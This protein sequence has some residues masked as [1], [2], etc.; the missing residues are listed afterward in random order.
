[1]DLAATESPKTVR[2]ALGEAFVQGL[3]TREALSGLLERHPRA[4]GLG[5]LRALLDEDPALTRSDAEDQFRT[6]MERA[7]LPRPAV[8][9]SVEGR[10]RDFVWRGR[11]L[12]VEVDGF[13]YHSGRTRFV[14]DRR[15]DG[16]LV[17]AGFRVL[18]V[19]WQ[20]LQEEPEAVVA[21]IAQALAR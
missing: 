17:A 19:T 20:Q 13:R 10:E 11:R 8:N 12:V 5:V 14:G 15:R 7:R 3:A 21:C 16:E 6:L 2:R 9:A 1:M 4:A 18:R